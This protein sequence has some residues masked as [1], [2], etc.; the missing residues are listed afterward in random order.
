MYGPASS[1]PYMSGA[2]LIIE[3]APDASSITT[4]EIDR[5]RKE[6]D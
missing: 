6:E 2:P 1:S 5:G 4:Q 3:I